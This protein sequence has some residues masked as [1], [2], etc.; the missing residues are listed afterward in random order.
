MVIHLAPEKV[1]SSAKEY[2]NLHQLGYQQPQLDGNGPR[3]RLRLREITNATGSSGQ[4][5]CSTLVPIASLCF[6]AAHPVSNFVNN[7]RNQARTALNPF[8]RRPAP[9]P[10]PDAEAPAEPPSTAL[11]R[12][13]AAEDIKAVLDEL[14]ELEHDH[15]A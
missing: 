13:F 12:A 15:G 5:I 9:L 3:R 2:P 10:F 4:A 7:V 14:E 1:V 8:K 6:T 11:E